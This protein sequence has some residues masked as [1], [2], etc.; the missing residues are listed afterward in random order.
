[1]L[2]E[3]LLLELQKK[4]IRKVPLYECSEFTNDYMNPVPLEKIELPPSVYA[5]FAVL[6]PDDSMTPDYNENDVLFISNFSRNRHLPFLIIYNDR[7]SVPRC[8]I[9]FVSEFKY[10]PQVELFSKNDE[11]IYVDKAFIKILGKVVWRKSV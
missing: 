11:P 2:P 7:T 5:E 3:H 9:R 6:M 8:N 1:M 4:K 10:N